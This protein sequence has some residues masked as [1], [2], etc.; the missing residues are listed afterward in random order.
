MESLGVGQRRYQ[1]HQKEVDMTKQQSFKRRVRARMAK[2]GEKY[3]AARLNVIDQG[4]RAWV[5]NPELTDEA[6]LEATGRGW[7]EWVEVLDSTG[8][9]DQEHGWIA[10]KVHELGVG[11]WWAQSVA[12]GYERITGLRLPNQGRDGMFTAGKSK[13]I[14]VS[15]TELRSM[16]LNESDRSD[17]F[18]GLESELRSRPDAKSLRF[19]LDE[20]IVMFSVTDKGDGR[21][22]VTVT[23]EKLADPDQVEFWKKFWEEWLTVLDES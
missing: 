17:L 14:Q 12:V 23:H 15:E 7:N 2:T 1:R 3:N 11:D 19:G 21:S 8:A 22:A 18:G 6:I 10:K 5:S 4:D 13:T 20:G 9:R 16:L